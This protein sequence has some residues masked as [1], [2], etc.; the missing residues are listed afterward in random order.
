MMH[1]F[2][3][4]LSIGLATLMT[5]SSLPVFASASSAFK[6]E[7]EYKY[8]DSIGSVSSDF[9]DNGTSVGKDTTQG[10]ESA[11]KHPFVDSSSTTID[12]TLEQTEVYATVAPAYGIKIP[13][14][15][16]LSASGLGLYDIG[17]SGDLTGTQ[18]LTIRPVDKIENTDDIDFYMAEQG[19]FIG[20]KD[21]IVAKVDQT[22]TT[23]TYS[24]M[25]KGEY[26]WLEE[27][28]KITA[29]DISAGSWA[30]TFDFLISM[31]TFEVSQSEYFTLYAPSVDSESN[32]GAGADGTWSPINLY[33]D[34]ESTNVTQ[35][36]DWEKIDNSWQNDLFSRA[37][38]ARSYRN[39]YK[40]SYYAAAILHHISLSY[41]NAEFDPG[42]IAAVQES[43]AAA[44]AYFRANY[45]EDLV[46]DAFDKLN[47]FNV[48]NVAN[49]AID[50]TCENLLNKANNYVESYG[51]SLYSGIMLAFLGVTDTE[52]IN[53]IKQHDTDR[54]TID[55]FVNE[56]YL[57]MIKEVMGIPET[58]NVNCFNDVLEYTYDFNADELIR[59]SET[60]IIPI[61]N[62][63]MTPTAEYSSVSE[64]S[65]VSFTFTVPQAQNIT[66]EFGSSD[67]MGISFESSPNTDTLKLLNIKGAERADVLALKED[68]DFGS[69]TTYESIAYNYIIA[70]YDEDDG[71]T[72][73]ELWYGKKWEILWNN[74]EAFTI[75]EW[76]KYCDEGI[77]PERVGIELVVEHDV[78]KHLRG[79]DYSHYTKYFEAGTYTIYVAAIGDA[80]IEIPSAVIVTKAGEN[81]KPDDSVEEIWNESTKAYLAI[82]PEYNYYTEAS[83]KEFLSTGDESV[84]IKNTSRKQLP[85]DLVLPSELYG[86]Q[87][88]GLV[89][90]AL[91]GYEEV[92]YVYA[93]QTYTELDATALSNTNIREIVI[94]D[95]SLT[96]INA[97]AFNNNTSLEIITLPDDIIAIPVFINCP[98]LKKVT[99]N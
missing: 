93:P 49:H 64:E 12:E 38:G 84:L 17:V 99:S 15:L 27:A 43:D 57:S 92:E 52:I 94:R 66:F 29:D 39:T 22:K 60:D 2:N 86:Y 28:G 23:W 37:D 51:L 76:I 11:T 32:M 47:D 34:S 3:K 35:T 75:D 81:S 19:A 79:G 56:N 71:Y 95:G 96:N 90:Y 70:N 10:K 4:A 98:K 61:R 44:E 59:Y 13:K 14:T 89:P 24:E 54:D 30:G 53:L 7:G 77:V 41:P 67:I 36:G 69:M 26:T 68:P 33:L 20:A 16:I 97:A 9:T 72:F 6:S 82:A 50:R 5:C 55:K 45:P 8:Q 85:K 74:N 48:D 63:L 62:A 78:D 80:S 88:T 42:M 18:K 83:F 87:I 1:R 25:R 91:R 58:A 73:D 46:Y 65:S 21:D 40:T 31:G